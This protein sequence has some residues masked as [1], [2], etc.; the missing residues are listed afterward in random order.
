MSAPDGFTREER[1][2][3][4]LTRHVL[5]RV[6]VVSAIAV[7]VLLIVFVGPLIHQK[8]YPWDQASP[9]AAPVPTL[10]PGT[11]AAVATAM[12]GLAAQVTA[13]TYAPPVAPDPAVAVARE[14]GRLA[15]LSRVAPGDPAA[16]STFGTVVL[17][18]RDAPYGLSDLVDAGAAAP[19][20]ENT[21]ALTRNVVV[22]AG[23]TLSL[24]QPGATLRLHS[25]SDGFVSIVAWGGSLDLHGGAD[26]PLTITGWDAEAGAPDDATD[27]G[28][29]YLRV[30]DGVLTMSD[31]HVDHLGFWSGRTGGLAVTGSDTGSARADLARVSSE[32]SHYGLFL[33]GVVDTTVT[34]FSSIAAEVSG[35]AVTGQS[36][37]V[38]L[39]GVDVDASG[40]DGI[41]VGGGSSTVGIGDATVRDSGE[42]GLRLSGRALATG[43]TAA[44]YGTDRSSGF[45]VKGGTFADNARG[46]LLLEEADGTILTGVTARETAA[47]VRANG[48]AKRLEIVG[49][50]LTSSAEPAV[51]IADGVVPAVVTGNVLH[52]QGAALRVAASVADVEHNDITVGLGNAVAVVG[53]GRVTVA[54]NV[55]GGIGQDAVA[56]SD[57]AAP[58][59]QGND[60][61]TWEFRSDFVTWLNAH[62]MAWMWLSVLVIPLVGV[63]LLWRRRV[64]HRQ[65]R[66]LLEQAIVQYGQQRIAAYGVD[67]TVTST[68]ELAAAP[69]TAP[70]SAEPAVTPDAPAEPAP[71][72][73]RTP[74]PARPHPARPATSARAAAASASAAASGPSP[75]PSP[76]P[77]IATD[78]GAASGAPVA[79]PRSLADLRTGALADRDFDSMRQFAVAAVLEAGYPLSTISRMFRVPAWRLQT[80]LE[81]AVEEA[82]RPP[83]PG[84]RPR[85]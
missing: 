69:A 2:D 56:T 63:P 46:G 52:G 39:S 12:S 71:Q 50:D 67:G 65:L 59:V 57:G 79:R 23:A 6:V 81:E 20:G 47:A 73:P 70:A 29:A 9:T 31:V 42:Y 41:Q 1:G 64:R 22:R 26:A 55:L 85:R 40:D 17:A 54:K 35:V 61:R 32:D 7:F 84:V 10:P 44:G 53:E 19:D 51:V 83:E 43:P 11:A 34:S 13:G 16:L 4:T 25:G 28:R 78:A 66:R 49:C 48:P 36:Q 68:E 24:V 76:S 45:A 75:S 15:G 5:G 80:W 82:S 21:W 27:D 62:P 38:A 8:G 58:T 37:R 14:D 72:G 33:S 30:R 60:T 3:T 18:A 77:G 74:P